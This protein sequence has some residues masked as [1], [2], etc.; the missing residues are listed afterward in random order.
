MSLGFCGGRSRVSSSL[1]VFLDSWGSKWSPW[2]QVHSNLI[3]VMVL[4]QEEVYYLVFTEL[5]LFFFLFLFFFFFFLVVSRDI[6]IGS[7]SSNNA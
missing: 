5:A 2:I 3:I 4:S 6:E 7:T 1:R